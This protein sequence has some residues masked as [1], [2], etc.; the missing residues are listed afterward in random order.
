MQ[1]SYSPR[2]HNQ[3]DYH[4]LSNGYA[5]VFMHKNE[6]SEEDEEGN[7]IYV[8][9]EVYFQVTQDVTKE[10]IEANF[11]YM[12]QDAQIKS[13]APTAEERLEVL[14]AALLDMILGGDM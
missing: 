9:D 10:E 7:L 2:P 11:K 5:D 3:V 4:K 8:A 12:W 14:E 13:Y 6:A 1:K